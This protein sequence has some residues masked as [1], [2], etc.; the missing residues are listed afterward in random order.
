MSYLR[1]NCPACSHSEETPA[2]DLF[3]RLRGAGL[4]R[5]VKAEEVRDL[6]YLLQ[7]AGSVK[8][9]L[10]CPN[11]GEGNYQ[12]H[13]FTDEGADWGDGRKCVGCQALISA[14]RLE[15]FPD[16]TLCR[17]CQ[18]KSEKGVAGEVEYCPRCGTPMQ[19]RQ[20]RGRGIAAYELA[21]PSCG[22]RG[23]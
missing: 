9:K 2:D 11:C 19:V 7:L 22:G 8:E 21:C 23:R 1:W 20:R 4:L 5:R 13:T 12:P 17:A 3:Q 14:E 18:Q 6:A 10:T 15:V 16:T